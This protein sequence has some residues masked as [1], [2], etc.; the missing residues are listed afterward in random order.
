MFNEI[1][2]AKTFDL[3][4]ENTSDH[5]PIM[6]KLNQRKFSDCTTTL[7]DECCIASKKR[8]KIRWSKFS[9]KKVH[10]KYVIALLSDLSAVGM[11]DLIDSK[12]AADKLSQ[13]LI[14]NCL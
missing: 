4:T 12:T 1:R 9:S 5:L 13:M 10:K 7:S 2:S 6:V 14:D 8:P 11:C 3:F